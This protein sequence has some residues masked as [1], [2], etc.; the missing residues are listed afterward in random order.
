MGRW[1]ACLI[2]HLFSLSTHPPTFLPPK[3]Q[4]TIHRLEGEIAAL[5]G[6]LGG[7]ED[8]IGSLQY[9][10]H[11]YIPP[12]HPPTHPPKSRESTPL[13]R[14]CL[15]TISTTQT[16]HCSHPTHNLNHSPTHPPTHPPTHL[17]MARL[18]RQVDNLTSELSEVKGGGGGKKGGLAL[19]GK[20]NTLGV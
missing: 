1:V 13:I 10:V 15:L 18:S 17:Q 4:A 5:K 14:T 6:A 16:H 7:K 8:E 19:G 12:T 9:K 20:E 3:T 2:Q 11:I